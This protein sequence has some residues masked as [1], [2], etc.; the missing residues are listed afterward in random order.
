MAIKDFFRS[1]IKTEE[2]MLKKHKDAIMGVSVLAAL[3]GGVMVLGSIAGIFT[4][5][6]LLAFSI[7]ALIGLSTIG[8]VKRILKILKVELNL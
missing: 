4:I 5:P 1:N 7:P 2:M 6:S 8:E 3:M